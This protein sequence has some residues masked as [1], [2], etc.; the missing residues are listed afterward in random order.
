MKLV[1]KTNTYYLIFFIF[2]FPLMIAVDYYLIQYV[3]IN[4]VDDILQHESERI[5]FELKERGA[6]PHSN[7]V[8]DINPVN[9]D[10]LALN[11]F[12]DTLIYEAYAD[13]LIPY[14]T[15]EFTSM[16]DSQKVRVSIRHI[17]L[18]MNELIIWLFVTTTL[19]ILLLVTGLFFINQG[20]YKWAWKPFFKN[21]SKLTNYDITKKNPVYLEASNISEFQDLNKIVTGLMNRVK[22]DFHNLK[23]FNENI[24]HE[25][26]TPLAI[27]RN[28]MVLL[29]ESQN[30]S[31]K[32]LQW[33][34]AV[35]QEANKLSKIGKSLTLIS[36]IENQE[37]TRQDSV[38]IHAVVDNIVGN[39][40]EMV[41]FKNLE[42]KVELNPVKV[43]CDL[44]LANILFTNLIKNAVQHNQDGGYISMLLNEEKFE[45]INSGEDSKIE[46][47][48]LFHRFQ[49]GNTATDSLGLGLAINQK[50]CEL[51]GFRLNYDRLGGTHTFSLFF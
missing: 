45:I 10:Y 12:R 47:E 9:K 43:E 21:L 8:F 34:S 18:E 49:K 31:K 25:I 36:R 24:S 19:I 14:R 26:Q 48:L 2:L 20:I 37:F 3:V 50:I 40:E 28:K 38:D 39:M 41:K 33:V 44:I 17:L 42:I 1:T 22:K 32:E 35:Y 13:K 46:P 15:Y 4:E 6:V 11:V 16:V 27:I 30:L 5:S 23:E 29:L 7:Y 51:Y